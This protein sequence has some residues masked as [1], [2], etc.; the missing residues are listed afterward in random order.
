MRKKKRLREFTEAERRYRNL[1]DGSQPAHQNQL[2]NGTT[3]IYSHVVS[4]RGCLR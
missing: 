1:A 4:V 3:G 2:T